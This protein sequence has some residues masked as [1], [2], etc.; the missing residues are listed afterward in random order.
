MMKEGIG[1]GITC[2]LA[3]QSRFSPILTFTDMLCW[4]WCSS[5]PGIT[6]SLTL[7]RASLVQS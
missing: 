7:Q 4:L 6:R 3:L 1:V 5:M 2:S